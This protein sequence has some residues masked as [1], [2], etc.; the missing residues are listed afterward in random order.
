MRQR[1]VGRH[2]LLRVG[3]IGALLLLQRHRLFVRIVS[4]VVV[5]CQTVMVLRVIGD[6]TAVHSDT[7]V[8]RMR[9]SGASPVLCQLLFFFLFVVRLSS[10]FFSRHARARRDG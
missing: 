6:E 7:P 4:R 1:Q 9:C 10:F 8:A 2:R 5:T 3:V